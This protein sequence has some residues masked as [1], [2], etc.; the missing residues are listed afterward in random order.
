MI[1]KKSHFGH[2]PERQR[3]GVSHGERKRERGATMHSAIHRNVATVE[4]ENLFGNG[5]PKANPTC[6]ILVAL[7]SA[8]EALEDVGEIFWGNPR[9]RVRHLYGN[10]RALERERHRNGPARRGILQGVLEE[11]VQHPLD[12]TDIGP[13][14]GEV[15]S[16]LGLEEL[17]FLVGH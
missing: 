6:S 14:K 12:E 2:T 10:A 4:L 16:Q 13:D 8:V 7:R 3:L 9:A 15:V 11:I 17:L 5:Q 1:T